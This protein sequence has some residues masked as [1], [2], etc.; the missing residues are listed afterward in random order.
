VRYQLSAHKLE[1]L[2]SDK[3]QVIHVNEKDPANQ[4]PAQSNTIP[5][6]YL[7]GLGVGL[8]LLV[9]IIVLLEIST[10]SKT[11]DQVDTAL[12]PA[13]TKAREVKLVSVV[14]ECQKITSAMD[15]TGT[16]EGS[17][18]YIYLQGYLENRGDVSVKFVRVQLLWRNKEGKTVEVGEVFAVRDEPLAPGER[19]SFEDSKKNYL[20]QKCGSKVLDWW[21]V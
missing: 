13:E 8:I 2:Q 15:Y 10:S 7:I 17:S 19:A 9:T 14:T 18:D 6:R 20:I 21:A 1:Y 16:T 4:N 12:P 5:T 3:N 11:E